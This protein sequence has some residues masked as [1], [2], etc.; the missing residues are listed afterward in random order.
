MD[1][2]IDKFLRL[3]PCLPSFNSIEWIP[4]EFIK[5]KLRAPIV[6]SI[7]LNG[8]PAQGGLKARASFE[9]FQFH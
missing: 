5:R 9:D 1:S 8:F 4:F 3:H 6:L 2:S 7:P